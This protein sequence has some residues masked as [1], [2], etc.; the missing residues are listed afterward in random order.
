[1]YSSDPAATGTGHKSNLRVELA[2][3][4]A[5]VRASQQLRYRIFAEEMGARVQIGPECTEHDRYDRHCH[6]LLVRESDSGRVV[7]STR[8]LT[9]KS[10]QRS[11]VKF[12]KSGYSF[13]FVL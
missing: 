2:H 8:I 5:A 1:M 13:R 12:R 6:H 7:S 10:A 11:D 3:D 9:G 4:E